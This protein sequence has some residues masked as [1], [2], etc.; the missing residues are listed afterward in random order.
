[1]G[2]PVVL[3]LLMQL[4]SLVGSLGTSSNA[5]LTTPFSAWHGLVREDRY[6][7]PLWQGALVSLAWALACLVPARLVLL[8]RDVR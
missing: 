7:G 8:R 5:L 4:L 1:V 6:Y 3:S 2:G